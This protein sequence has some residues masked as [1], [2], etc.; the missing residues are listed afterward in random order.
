MP[1]DVLSHGNVAVLVILAMLVI[2]LIVAAMNSLLRTAAF[3]VKLGQRL[4]SAGS[5]E[6]THA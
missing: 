3:L 4:S 6:S 5:E 2:G 1:C